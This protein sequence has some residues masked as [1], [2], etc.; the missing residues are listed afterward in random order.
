MTEWHC[1]VNGRQYGPVDEET[2]RLWIRHGRC[3]P[4]DRVWSPGM[5][6]WQEARTQT[7]FVEA[8]RDVPSVVPRHY[9]TAPGAV[10]SLALGI[11]GIMFNCLGLILGLIALQQQ[12]K[13]MAYIRSQPE[14]Y[15]GEGLCTAGKVL[16]IVAIIVGSL[17]LLYFA[18]WIVFV[19]AMGL[20]H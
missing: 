9:E 5:P 2:L 12:R 8:C 18:C 13:A 7:P 19:V 4:T 20:L 16:G 6:Q 14:R 1:L 11:A 15:T 3:R 10:A 17:S